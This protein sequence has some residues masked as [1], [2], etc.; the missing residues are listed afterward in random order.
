MRK[1]KRKF[2]A[3]E[4]VAILKRHLCGKE[5]V[6]DIC[7]EI[8]VN[9]RLGLTRLLSLWCDPPVIKKTG[10]ISSLLDIRFT[11]FF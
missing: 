8:G 4:K 1:S 2:E 10:L 5:A 3:E 9:N 7:E 6:S 11:S